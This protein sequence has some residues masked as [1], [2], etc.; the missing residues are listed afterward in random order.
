MLI[1]RFSQSILLVVAALILPGCTP[2]VSPEMAALTLSVPEVPTRPKTDLAVRNFCGGCHVL[3]SSESFGHDRWVEEVKQGFRLYAESGRDDLVV[4][5]YEAT[6]AFFQKAAPEDWSFEEKKSQP[7]TRFRKLEIPWD[8]DPLPVQISHVGPLQRADVGP[9]KRAIDKAAG[10]PKWV[11]TDMWTGHVLEI[12]QEPDRVRATTIAE[13]SHPADADWVDLDGD[14]DRDFVVADLGSYLPEDSDQS[15]VWFLENRGDE[16][17]RRTPLR[18][19]L[20]RTAGI[21]SLD[22]DQDG[23]ADLV[24]SDFGRH[25]VG[26]VH[27]LSN[28]GN[29]NPAAGSPVVGKTDQDS[30]GPKFDW[31][32]LDGRSGGIDSPIADIDGNGLPDIVS[33]VSQHYEAVEVHLN[34]GQGNFESQ[35]IFRASDPSYGSSG[36]EVVDLDGDGDLDVVYTNGDTFDDTLAKPYHCIRWFENEGRYPFTPHTITSMPGVYCAV[37]GDLD[38]DGDLDI[39][40]VALLDD[41][42]VARYPAGQ[43]DGILWLEQTDSGVFQR[44]SIL[45]DRCHAATCHLAD[46]DHDGDLD[47]IVPPFEFDRSSVDVLTVYINETVQPATDDS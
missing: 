14:G 19:G 8:G 24:V 16:G 28:Q 44:H 6:L 22:Y 23:D 26:A 36:I 38:N 10:P 18:L 12:T 33:L 42:E 3:P 1:S 21:E 13:V 45:A 11:L 15:S 39:A 29:K 31:R 17:Y 2:D 41:A 9:S 27:L 35:T 25:F 46:W 32:A 20:S 40:A 4:P 7:D 37:T 47:L 34:K 30:G 5:D 43:F